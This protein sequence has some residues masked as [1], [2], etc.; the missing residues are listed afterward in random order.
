MAEEHPPLW[1]VWVPGE[2]APQMHRSPESAS[3]QA[4]LAA[5]LHVGVTVHLYQLK[6]VGSI[7]YPNRPLIIGDVKKV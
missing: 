7:T 3:A 5:R 2:E 6:S 1:F 4:D